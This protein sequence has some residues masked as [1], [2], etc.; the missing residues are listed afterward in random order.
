MFTSQA[1]I[2]SLYLQILTLYSAL[3]TLNTRLW[4]H[5]CFILTER[6]NS[7]TLSPRK[8][9]TPYEADIRHIALNYAIA[10]HTAI[11]EELLMIS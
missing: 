5:Q 2:N 7:S 3:N 6:L 8:L 4:S 10:T 11:I 1:Q 9:E